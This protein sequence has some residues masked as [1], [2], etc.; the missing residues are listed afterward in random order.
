MVGWITAFKII[1]W[2]HVIAAAP[3]VVRGARRLWTAVRDKDADSPLDGSAQTPEARLQAL[4]ARVEALGKELTAASE[5]I[6]SLAEQNARLVEFVG[7]LRVRTRV[8]LAAGAIQLVL[9]AGIG[10][11]LVFH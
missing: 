8:L 5:L 4:E 11:W 7:V 9:L 6:H 1:P 2:A 3:A 10:A